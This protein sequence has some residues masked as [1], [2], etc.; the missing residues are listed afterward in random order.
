[1]RALPLLAVI[2][3]LLCGPATAFASDPDFSIP[4]GWFFSQAGGS[5][6]L[7]YAITNDGGVAFWRDFQRLGGVASLGYPSS[8]RFVGS[9][10]F[11]YQATQGALLQWRPDEET[12]VL[13]NSFDLLSAANKDD[14][15]KARSIP[16]PVADDGSR[17]DAARSYQIRLSWLEDDAIRAYYLANPNPADLTDWSAQKAVQLYGLPMSHPVRQGPFVVQ[18]FQRVAIQRWVELVPG[19]PRPGTVTKV[20]A[21]DLLKDAGLLPAAS[22]QPAAAGSASARIEPDLRAPLELLSGV[23]PAKPLYDLALTRPLAVVWA[24]MPGDVAGLYSARRRWIA[25][26]LRW[27]DAD[28]KAIATLLSHE[29]SHAR[30]FFG[31]KAIWTSDGCF[32]TE[33]DAFRTQAQVWEAFYGPGGKTGELSEIDRQQNFVL[34]SIH[35]DPDGFAAR[36]QQVYQPE[37]GQSRG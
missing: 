14:W 21:G 3:L 35:R 8:W 29:L 1:M 31:D 25:I 16:P 34:G 6:G 7:G 11:V 13:A 32:Q 9:D 4:N 2:V 30:D 5:G 37:C 24:P 19:M 22:A 26:N 28:P 27:K 33:Q 23:G 17:G 20:L 15:L 10:G 36:V 12:T 18:R